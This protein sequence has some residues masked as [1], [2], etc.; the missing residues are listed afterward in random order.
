M[1]INELG[2]PVKHLLWLSMR[3]GL[4]ALG[5][6]FSEEKHA[7]GSGDSDSK[8]AI[9]PLKLM[10]S[11]MILVLILCIACLGLA[12]VCTSYHLLYV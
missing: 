12:A 4:E 10:L 6:Y 8:K 2:T 11:M 5:E 9:M 1:E 3:G 7:D